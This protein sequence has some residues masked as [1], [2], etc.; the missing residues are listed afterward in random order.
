MLIDSFCRWLLQSAHVAG[1]LAGLWSFA[2]PA[3]AASWPVPLAGNAYLT[4][5]SEGTADAIGRAG[6]MRW[7]DPASVVSIYF[8]VDRPA[9]LD[10]ALRLQVPEGESVIQ[11]RVGDAVFETRVTGAEVHEVPLGKV[12]VKIAGYVRVDLK[13]IRHTGPVFAEVSD[14][15]VS[16]GTEGLAPDFVKNN[17][18]NM[19][20][21]GRRGP[22]VHLSYQMPRGREVEYAYSELTVPEGGDA[23]GSY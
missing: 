22:S 2:E 16:S 3:F 11:A 20:Y 5:S 19:F 13:G 14:L 23:I 18:G 21:W 1:F 4:S 6:R 9:S 17:E 8:R 15:V 12:E 10:L 7:Q